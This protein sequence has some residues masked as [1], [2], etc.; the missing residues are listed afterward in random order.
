M[1]RQIAILGLA[2]ALSACGRH[3][4]GGAVTVAAAKPFPG[5]LKPLDSTYRPVRLSDRVFAREGRTYVPMDFQMHGAELVFDAAKEQAFGHSVI[6]FQVAEAGRP[7]FFA[8]SEWTAASLNGAAVDLE[9]IL[10]PGEGG[11]AWALSAD[12]R[13]NELNILTL[14]YRLSPARVKFENGGVGFL[15]SMT[16]LEGHFAERWLPANDESDQYSLSL[17]LTV[18]GGAPGHRLF[19][20]GTVTDLGGD[21]WIVSFPAHFNSSALYVHLTNRPFEVRRLGVFGPQ[22]AIPITL[23]GTEAGLL[24]RAAAMLP[25]LFDE[26]QTAYGPYPHS[27]FTAYV[28]ASGGGMEYAGATISSLG[29]LDHEL[30]HSWFARGV[31]PAEGRSGWIDE[32]MA[33]WRDYGYARAAAL[34]QRAPTALAPADPFAPMTVRNCYR[35]GRAL[36]AELDRVLEA[37]G[38]MKAAM[39]VFFE[40]YKY[41]VVTTEEFQSFLSELAQK[42]LSPYFERYVYAAVPA[43]E[44]ADADPFHPPPISEAE[45]ARLR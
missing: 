31:F 35:D 24:D 16:D 41:R 42:D 12:A 25:P 32:A 21:Q 36:M 28:K 13:P 2:L 18:N 44:N 23:Y 27:S 14:E 15:T 34:L 3:G 45:A 20:N 1:I 5:F 11:K 43:G 26:L 40:R 10:L 37:Y 8:E 29:S 39:R 22:G 4:G 38:G 30:F 9:Q 6:L 19:T 7:V 17:R 33:S